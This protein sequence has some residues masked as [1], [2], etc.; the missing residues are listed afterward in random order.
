MVVYEKIFFFI[1]S[2][3][4][5]MLKY[6]HPTSWYTFIDITKEI[7]A[8]LRLF[9]ICFLFWVQMYSNF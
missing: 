8:M 1:F 9:N 2:S 3:L 5:E 6:L 7:R 4:Q